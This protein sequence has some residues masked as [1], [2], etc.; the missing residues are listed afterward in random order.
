MQNNVGMYVGGG[1]L[2]MHRSYSY[3]Y[4]V[5]LQEIL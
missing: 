3:R 5:M 2:D 1:L 4:N